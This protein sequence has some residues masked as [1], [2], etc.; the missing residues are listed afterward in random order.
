MEFALLE[1]HPIDFGRLRIRRKDGRWMLLPV[2]PCLLKI[3][4]RAVLVDA[5]FDPG[6]EK[7]VDGVE[8]RRPK[9]DLVEQLGALGLWPDDV[10]DVI[11]THLHDDH[12]SGVLDHATG[13][14]VFP[15]ARVHVQDLA[16]WKGLE[17]VA[18]GGERFV[19]G[20]LLEHLASSPSTVGHHGDWS[21]CEGVGVFHS[22]GHTPGHQIVYAGTGAL[23]RPDPA[24]G[25]VHE[26]PAADGDLLLAG[27]L[28]SLKVCFDPGFRTSSDVDPE[29]ALL[30]RRELARLS[31]V[32][33]YLYHAPPS[34]R[35]HRQ[36]AERQIGAGQSGE[37]D[38]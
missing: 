36:E 23:R 16:L 17:R 24:G 31:G 18:R 26:P 30:R 38:A 35:F 32:A 19:S 21:L 28:L 14:P 33:H 34:G 12:A 6:L 25:F 10:A 4:S 22:G 3:G 8:W 5:G 7:R 29:T 13:R 37:E 1:A 20:E 27:D 15:N 2:A 9:A 11:L